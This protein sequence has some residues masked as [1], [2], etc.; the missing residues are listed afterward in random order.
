[1]VNIFSC[2]S[3]KK[4]CNHTHKIQSLDCKM[5]L[6]NYLSIYTIH[7]YIIIRVYSGFSLVENCDL[8][9]DRR[10]LTPFQRQANH[11]NF[12]IIDNQWRAFFCIDHDTSNGVLK[13]FGHTTKHIL[14]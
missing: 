12:R 2:F 9:K 1:M 7:N 14:A 4:Y 11:S 10:T 6:I 3:F 13:S 5:M 8:L